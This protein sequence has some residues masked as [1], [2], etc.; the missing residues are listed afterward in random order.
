MPHHPFLVPLEKAL[1]VYAALAIAIILF[2]GLGLAMYLANVW[3]RLSAE[4]S[5]TTAWLVGGAVL[6]GLVRSCLWIKIYWSGATG[7]SIMRGNASSHELA[8]RLAPI[9]KTLTKLLVM[10][11]V[12]D[13]LLLPAYFMADLWFPFPLAG[14]RLGAVE[15][16][17]LLFPQAF[18]LATLILAFLTHQ[19][20]QLL[21][22]RSRM[23]SE[24][25]LTI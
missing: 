6:M 4:I 22:E 15:L 20:A 8:E 11:C 9:L 2:Q 18:G 19:Y 23:Q 7:L 25:E 17:R 5:G 10:S 24:L 12:L 14:W 21:M 3:P 1:R 16:A 13:F